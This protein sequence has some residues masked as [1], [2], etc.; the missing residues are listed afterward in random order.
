MASLQKRG[1][2]YYVRF[3]SGSGVDRKEV[4]FSLKTSRKE[5]AEKKL[6]ILERKYEEETIQP[7]SSNFDL[8]RALKDISE[9][10]KPKTLDESLSKLLESK[11]QYKKRSRDIYK[12]VINYFLDFNHLHKKPLNSIEKEHFINFLFRPGIAT[13]TRYTNRQNLRTWWRFL[14]KNK[15]VKK[16][17]VSD[18][19]LPQK[20]ATILKKMITEEE[21]QRLFTVFDHHICSIRKNKYHRI[22]FEQPWF[23]P[24]I[25]ILFDAGLRLHECLYNPDQAEKNNDNYT[26]LCGKNI[27]GDFEF[28][29]IEKAKMNRE[30]LIPITTRLRKELKKYY[31]IRGVPGANDYIF[32]TYRG[33]PMKGNHARKEFKKYLRM[34][35]IPVTRTFHGMRHRTATTWLEMGFTLPEV[36]N[37]LGHSSVKITDEVYTHLAA[38]NLKRKMDRLESNNDE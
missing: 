1:K 33:K 3:I 22:Y 34:A 14:L 23:K 5:I 37:M 36:K 6:N 38:K 26:G 31:K 24:V 35:A 15:W 18:I 28:I 25:L 11:K 20:D 7:F 30:R 10:K 8:N 29:Y 4:K 13:Q 21:I 12:E 2:Y 27:I 19:N 16:D 32:I 17:L 9:E